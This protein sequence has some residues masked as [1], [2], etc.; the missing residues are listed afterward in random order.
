[1]RKPG[2]THSNDQD[3]FLNIPFDQKYEPLFVA[4]IAGISGLGLTP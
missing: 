3:V 2:R 1:M 4:F